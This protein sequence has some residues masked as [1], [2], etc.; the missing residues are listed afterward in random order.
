[1][2]KN[3]GWVKLWREQFGHEISDRKPWC[4]GYALVISMPVPITRPVS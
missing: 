1:M 4:D 3:K 2:E